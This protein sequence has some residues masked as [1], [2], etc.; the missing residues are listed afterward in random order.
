MNVVNLKIT[1]QD[2]LLGRVICVS[3]SQIVT[4]VE[5]RFTQGNVD[6]PSPIQKGRLVKMPTADSVVFGMV[7]GLSVPAPSQDAPDSEI[8][9]IEIEVLGEAPYGP[10]GLPGAFQRGVSVFPALG[11]GVFATNQEDLT[12]VY[13]RP[14]RKTVRIGTIHQDKSLPATISP[15]D[16]MGKHFAILGTTGS[17][18]SC[19]VTL[20]L[21]SILNEHPNA[22]IVLMDPHAEYATAFG[23][24]A[25]VV[26]TDSLQ[27]PYWL[28]NFEEIVEIVLGG[29]GRGVIS[30]IE[31]SI[32]RELITTA[33]KKQNQ[34]AEDPLSITA[35]TPVPYGMSDLVTQLD[36]LMGKLDKAE[37]LAPYL[38]VKTRIQAL[39]DDA[40]F[41]FIFGGISVR[42]NMAKIISRLF[43]I[44]VNGKPITTIDL[45]SVPSE[46][47]NVVVSVLSRLTFDF[48][49]WSE[50][51]VPILLVCEEAHRY[52]PQDPS[53][54][55]EPTKKALARIAKE[56]RKYGVSLGV[57]SQRPSELAAE[58]LSQCNTVFAL[59]MS[60][61]RDQ[62]F[63]RGAMSD[64]AVGLLDF[65][66]SLRNGE[67]IAVGEGVSV[68]MRLRFDALPDDKMPRSGTANFSTAWQD[69]NQDEAFVQ[70]VIDRW[71]RQ[72]R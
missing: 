30:E 4:L 1:D 40:R 19:A 50:R 53:A 69:D 33:K 20:V 42:D 29:E 55:F 17:G 6:E 31:S 46:V 21:N 64:T 71:R 51:S 63:V 43:R 47:L 72:R 22:H 3:G 28:L 26:D 34:N 24:A 27:L 45:S 54:G 8:K 59:R 58:V 70:A 57:V 2:Q 48:A 12:R 36:A 25:A 9:I 52:A 67:A 68:P 15:D 23:D 39:R 66:P 35:D 38:R 61:Q 18:K 11:D 37:Q 13:A 65:L 16:L 44:P 49:L 5:D 56:G 41:N 7:D 10:D 60:N 32:L 14:D 62:D